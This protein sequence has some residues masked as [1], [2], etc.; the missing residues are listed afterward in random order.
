MSMYCCIMLPCEPAR[1]KQAGGQSA[2]PFLTWQSCCKLPN[3]SVC[4]ARQACQ[5]RQGQARV[6]LPCDGYNHQGHI[7]L[8]VE[9]SLL[10][11]QKDLGHVLW[12]KILCLGDA[13]GVR[14]PVLHILFIGPGAAQATGAPSAAPEA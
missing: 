7:L 3:T 9:V 11:V 12:T 8:G 1:C 14:G 4:Q 2:T 6:S 5:A 10:L 13:E